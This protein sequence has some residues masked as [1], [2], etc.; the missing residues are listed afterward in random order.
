MI[1]VIINSLSWT[2]IILILIRGIVSTF[3][4]GYEASWFDKVKKITKPFLLPLSPPFGLISYI[5]S[6][7]GVRLLSKILIWLF[8]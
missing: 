8:V 3:F 6:I 7:I 5:V 2:L 1:D 4:V